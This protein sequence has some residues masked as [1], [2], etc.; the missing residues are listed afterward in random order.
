M[1]RLLAVLTLAVLL[2][3]A[4]PES[5]VKVTRQSAPEKALLFEVSVAAPPA[6]VWK[7]FSTREGMITWLAPDAAIDLQPGGDWL[8]MFPG[9]SSTGGGTI[10]S[11]VSG[12]EIVIKAMAPEAF[13]TV[14]R[15]RTTAVFRMEPAPEGCKVTLMQ[16][17]WK[18][19]DEWD[20]AYDYLA[21]GNAQLLE[22]LRKRFESGPI[23]WAAL[24]KGR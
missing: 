2:N 13:P 5:H 21:S 7:A 14:R 22:A 23:D 19:G 24:F 8:A 4:P 16:T 1:T 15:E 12:R 18:Q 20:K 17:G 10:V 9:S 3:A 6:E 11:F